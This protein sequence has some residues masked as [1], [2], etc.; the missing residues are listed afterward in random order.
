MRCETQLPISIIHRFRTQFAHHLPRLGFDGVAILGVVSFA[1]ATLWAAK[2]ETD[3][4]DA[5][6]AK[7]AASLLINSKFITSD[8][9]RDLDQKG[10]AVVKNVLLPEELSSARSS[11]LSILSEGRMH[12]A[13]GNS[14]SVRQDRVCFVRGNDG[15]PLAVDEASRTC[16]PVGTGLQHC[17]SLLRGVTLQLQ[18]LGFNRST[19][20]R[21]P[22]QCQLAHYTGNGNTSYVAHRDAASDTNFYEIGLLAW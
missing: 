7:D 19:N 17:I 16:K 14:I 1:A 5:Q 3:I 22:T 6:T 18:E 2:Y 9:V 20:H 11:S 15:T 12:Y 21:V 8:V 13:G 4:G 10:V